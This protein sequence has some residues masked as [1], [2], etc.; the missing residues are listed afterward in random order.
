MAVAA[1]E[2]GTGRKGA[3]TRE[4][5]MDIAEQ[6]VLDKGFGATSIDEIIAAAGLTKSGFIYHFPDKSALA[7]AL[8]TRYI[9]REDVL[10]DDIFARAAELSDD[11]LQ[12]LLIGLKLLAEL[13]DDLPTAHPGCLVA[14]YCYQERLFDREVRELNEQAVRGWRRRFL[15]M[16][17][18]VERAY[19]R[20]DDVRIDAVADMVTGAIEGGIV[21]SKAL[22]ERNILAEQVMLLRSY[23]KLLFTPARA[24]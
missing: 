9:E 13:L 6:A 16:L 23:I 21:L 17:E 24:A 3:I 1:A 4:R 5:I 22:N 12:R 20:Q 8:L 11:P 19:P 15:G 10:F 7:R 18:E 14:T 2:G